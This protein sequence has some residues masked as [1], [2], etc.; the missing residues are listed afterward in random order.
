MR[1]GEGLMQKAIASVVLGLMCL[2]GALTP[3]SV[4]SQ[5]P[6]AS[7][8]VARVI[9]T[10]DE[11]LQELLVLMSAGGSQT[12]RMTALEKRLSGEVETAAP[13]LLA[14]VRTGDRR[15]AEAAAY[16]LRY[17]PDPEPA[18]AALLDGLNRFD[19]ALVNNVGLSLEHFAMAHPA[20][21]IPVPRLAEALQ[22]T[23]WNQQQKVAQVLQVLV[24]RGGVTDPDGTLAETLVQMLASQRVRVFG[25]A[26]DM[27]SK[28]TTQALGNQPEDWARWYL[29]SRGRPIHLVNGIYEL[30]QI[31][32]PEI[33]DGQEVY[34][35]EGE[36][37]RT[38]D[39]LLARLRKDE[40]TTLDLNRRFGIV[41]QVPKDGFPQDRLEPLGEA[42]FRAVSPYN[43]TISPESDEFVPFSVALE[44]L[45]RLIEVAPVEGA[46]R[47]NER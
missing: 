9:A 14:A 3:R 28:I 6:V 35:V 16:A 22:A 47:E 11:I 39:A 40:R 12:E 1:A 34:R 43:L 30:V 27:L 7:P 46:D 26:R 8:D 44:R 23:Q 45:R 41:V 25:P 33:L 32:R 21:E 15:S 10:Y 38:R 2:I 17:A 37:Y 13:A 29:R 20:L 42:I 4:A 5:E 36:T 18:V 19:G 24:E 31:V